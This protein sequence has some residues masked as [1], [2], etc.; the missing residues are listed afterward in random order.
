VTKPV[1]S[2][3]D[4]LLSKYLS[5]P[6][7]LEAAKILLSAKDLNIDKYLEKNMSMSLGTGLVTLTDLTNAYGIIANGGKKISPKFIKSIYSKNGRQIFNGSVKKC[8]NCILKNISKYEKL[9]NIYDELEEVFDPKISYQITSMMEGVIQRGT[10]KNLRELNIP[11][12][13]KTGTTNDNKDAWFIGFSPDLVIG[14]YVGYDSPKSLGY[15]QTGSSVALPI[16][17]DFIKKSS[18]NKNKT[19]FRVPSG[20]SFVNINPKTGLPS[21]ETNSIIEAF[22]IG[23]EPYSTKDINI[24]D[25]LGIINNSI[26]G[27]GGLLNN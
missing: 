20:L 18:T 23:T 21:N 22:I 7:S 13:G 2:D 27:T 11:L 10:A 8:D 16:F 1:P 25:S 4:I 6:N 26:S 5:I 15:K 9:P 19:P 3:I 14:V 24:L 17:K 12:A